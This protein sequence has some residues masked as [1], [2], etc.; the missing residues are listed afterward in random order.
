MLEPNKIFIT[1]VYAKVIEEKVSVYMKMLRSKLNG[2]V[3]KSI[4]ILY[5][6][7]ILYLIFILLIYS[8]INLLN[9]G[10][11]IVELSYFCLP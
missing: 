1:Q 8:N 4:Y 7:S 11:L 3:N 10:K 5:H 2:I 9:N 6:I